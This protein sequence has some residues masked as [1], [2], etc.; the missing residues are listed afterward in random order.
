VLSRAL[1]AY[2][3]S[4]GLAKGDR[5]AVMMPN[6]PQYPVAVAAILRAGY[7]VVNVN[8]L[9]TPRELEHQ[10]K[11][12]GARGD[13]RSSR[14][15]RPRWQKVH[16][17]DAHVKHVIL[18]A[19]GDLLGFSKGAMVNFVVAQVKKLVPAYEPAGRG[20]RSTRRLR[21]GTRPPFK[22]PT[23]RPRRRC[24]AAVH[25]RHHRRVQGRRAAAPQSGRQRAAGRGLVPAGPEQDPAG[26]ADSPPSARCRCITSSPS[27]SDMMLAHAHGRTATC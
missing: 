9:Y 2:L 21:R 13:R 12:S 1:A 20:A 10:L 16:R 8:P 7:V 11:D 4:L 26:R 14:T 25:R 22:R 19:M 5:V 24:R 15:S 17:R 18:R 3:Q 27:P 23:L 6:V